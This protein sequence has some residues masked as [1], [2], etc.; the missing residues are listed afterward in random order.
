VE[1]QGKR[2]KLSMK[3]LG[4]DPGLASTGVVVIEVGDKLELLHKE[5]IRTKSSQKIPERLGMIAE[6]IRKVVDSYAPSLLALE[7]AFVRRDAP[8]AGLSLGKVLGVILLVVH[9][10]ELEFLE[11]TPRQA[12]ETLTGY[13]NASKEQMERA[14]AKSLGLS[15][16][17]RPS[18][19]ADAAAVALTA[20]S[21]VATLGKR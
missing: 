2:I 4:V 1:G 9:E 8:K 3:I 18:H 6:G 17:L 7:T 14:V 5:V 21:I 11:P 16:P 19:V 20:A 13:G 12:K 10:K 15:E